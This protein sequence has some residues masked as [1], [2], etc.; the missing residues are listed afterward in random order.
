MVDKSVETMMGVDGVLSARV[1]CMRCGGSHAV[2]ACDL[3][4]A[5]EFH[6]SGDLKR[7]EFLTA[8]DFAAQQPETPEADQSYPRLGQDGA[9]G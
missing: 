7:V 2:F 5:V 3:V 1:S 4:K 9:Q 8:A 6:E